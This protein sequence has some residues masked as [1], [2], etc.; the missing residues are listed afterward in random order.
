MPKALERKLMR[1]AKKQGLTGERKNAM[2]YGVMRKL[3]WK[4][5]REKENKKP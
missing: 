1:S 3:G 5:E 4:P 2:V